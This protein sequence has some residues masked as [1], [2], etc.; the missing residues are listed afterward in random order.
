MDGHQLNGYTLIREIGRGGMGCVYEGYSPKGKHV[1]VKM[2][3]S[4]VTINPEFRELFQLEVAALQKMSHHDVVKI[5]GSAFADSEGNL[6]L[7]MEFVEGQTI[8]QH[9]SKT[10]KPY[11]ETEAREIFNKVLDAFSYIHAAGCIHRDIKPANIL[12]NEVS[13]SVWL[14]VMDV[15]CLGED[16]RLWLGA[17]DCF[18]PAYTPQSPFHWTRVFQ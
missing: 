12:L 2:M 11:S 9:I 4:K 13:V 8:E 18:P 14:E 15:G 1:A 10:G 7:P 3:S 5:M 6:Y 17:G 16:L